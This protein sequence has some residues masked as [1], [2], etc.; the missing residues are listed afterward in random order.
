M[1]VGIWGSYGYGNY[2]DDVMAVI[3]AEETKREGHHPIVYRLNRRLAERH[4]VGCSEDLAELVSSSDLMIIG[5][6]A[7][8]TTLPWWKRLLRIHQTP[9]DHGAADL[10]AALSR[11]P[12]AIYSI[13]IGGDGTRVDAR[14]LPASVRSLFGSEFYRGGTVR[15]PSDRALLAALG[16]N[17]ECYPDVLLGLRDYWPSRNG[18][19]DASD[20]RWQIGVCL[21]RRRGGGLFR[22]LADYAAARRD[23]ELHVISSHLETQWRTNEVS[24]VPGCAGGT[25]RSYQHHDPVETA[26]FLGSLD[27]VIS[28]KLHVGITALSYGA[29]FLS[30]AGE[31]K[32]RAALRELG[33]ERLCWSYGAGGA[34]LRCLDGLLS[35]DG[36]RSE[37]L[38]WAAVGVARAGSLQHLRR[39]REILREHARSFP[40]AA[41]DTGEQRGRM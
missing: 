9:A 35:P 37:A 3:F 26:Q 17:A 39:Y 5:G 19:R 14:S 40:G 36:L 10:L 30:Y 6:G 33:L 23:V 25:V 1:N 29:M 22:A 21:S 24:V 8:L 28:T 18:G 12:R 13:S 15:L 4:G 16:K 34:L 11:S 38:D 2:G 20:D 7:M 32:T 27:V 41:Q 31:P